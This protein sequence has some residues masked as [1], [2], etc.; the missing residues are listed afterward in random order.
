MCHGVG[1]VAWDLQAALRCQW[2]CS[3]VRHGDMV[4]E[5]PPPS[6]S[7]RS[8]TASRPAAGTSGTPGT[9]I[10]YIFEQVATVARTII[11]SEK[12]ARCAWGAHA[13][14]AAAGTI[15]G[16]RYVAAGTQCASEPCRLLLPAATMVNANDLLRLAKGMA[17]PAPFG[18]Q[19]RPRPR[20]IRRRLRGSH[21]QARSRCCAPLAPRRLRPTA[22]VRSTAP[23]QV[24]DHRY[25]LH[26]YHQS[27]V[28]SEAVDWLL[29]SSACPNVRTR[30]LAT[31]LGIAMLKCARPPRRARHATL[32]RQCTVR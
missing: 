32:A 1:R 17:K 12:W 13:R 9:I 25:H 2:Q 10:T 15:S 8:S 11:H 26:T 3:W 27:F 29:G 4:T 20:E 19:A 18:V 5:P 22:P 28:G 24:S 6:P 14:T 7:P 21:A 30:D 31:A 16:A 23:P